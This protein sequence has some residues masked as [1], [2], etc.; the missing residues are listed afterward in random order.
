MVVNIC[1]CHDVY[2]KNVR[3]QFFVKCICVESVRGVV[4]QSYYLAR[5]F[6]VVFLTS[7]Y[8]LTKSLYI[9][10]SSWRFLFFPPWFIT[11][12]FSSIISVVDFSS[13][14]SVINERLIKLPPI[15]SATLTVIISVICS[16]YY[17]N[18]QSVISMTDTMWDKTFCSMFDG[19][20]QTLLWFESNRP[21][22]Y[23]A[24]IYHH[25]YDLR[26]TASFSV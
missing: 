1:L 24:V 20:L 25:L 12:E 14:I 13:I 5:I 26:M 18:N 19:C 22:P 3:L 4:K 21:F 16:F 15:V 11:S 6:C 7:W 2:I 10:L 9:F 17:L 8:E 23:L